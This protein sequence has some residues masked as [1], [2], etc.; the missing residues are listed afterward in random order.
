MDDLEST[1][2]NI[3]LNA[4]QSLLEITDSKVDWIY[5]V[6][7]HL[8]NKLNNENSYQRTLAIILL[9]NLAKSDTENRLEHSL[10][11]LLA[12]TRDDKFITSRKCLQNIWKVAATNSFNRKKVLRHLENRFAECAD[13]KHYNLLRQD[14]IQSIVLLHKVENDD[15]LL[16]KARAL[17]AEEKDVKYQKQYEA[18]L[19]VK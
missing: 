10:D 19:K 13:E 14:I 4:L 5:E 9:C 7:D 12:H 17:I 15:A 16:T 1:D 18:L 3:R 6:W 11:R 2:D 8:L